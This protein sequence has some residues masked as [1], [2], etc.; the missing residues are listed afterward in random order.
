MGAAILAGDL[1]TG[2]SLMCMDEGMDTG[3][4]LATRAE[5]VQPEDTTGSLEKRLVALGA[6]LLVQTLPAYLAGQLSP[7][8]QKDEAATYSRPVRKADGVIPWSRSAAEI[9][10]MVRAMDPWPGAFTWWNGRQ[11]R[12]LR[13][14]VGEDSARGGAT[15]EAVPSIPGT[16]VALG[17]GAGVVTGDGV[18]SLEVVQLEGR[19]VLPVAAFLNGNRGLIGTTLSAAGPAAGVDG[20]VGHR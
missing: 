12:V 9:E 11:L 2:V 10:R 15:T 1:E 8:P 16:V 18:L 3:P 20:R 7:Q 6:K 19:A 5:P 14:C 4:V 17:K 13:A